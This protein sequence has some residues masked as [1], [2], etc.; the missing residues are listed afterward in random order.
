MLL[1]ILALFFS[2]DLTVISLLLC[3][4]IQNILLPTIIPF[5]IMPFWKVFNYYCLK[6]NLDMRG[7]YFELF[8][9]E[10]SEKFRNFISRSVG[11]DIIYS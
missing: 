2:L 6:I 8:S 5:L 7:V 10:V 1:F 11:V 3:S 4:V 9:R